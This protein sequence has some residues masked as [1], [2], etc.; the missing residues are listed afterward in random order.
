MDMVKTMDCVVNAYFSGPMASEF[1]TTADH[2]KTEANKPM[3]HACKVRG[4]SLTS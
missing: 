2:I 3:E 1:E 4:T